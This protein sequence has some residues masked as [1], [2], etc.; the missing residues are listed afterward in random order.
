MNFGTQIVKILLYRN[1]A[2][3]KLARPD[4]SRHFGFQNGRQLG[5]V[6]LF[7]NISRRKTIRE[8]ITK[9]NILKV[10]KYPPQTLL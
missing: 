9:I 7:S 1:F 8:L 10:L 3:S 5:P 6:S 2:R 4:F